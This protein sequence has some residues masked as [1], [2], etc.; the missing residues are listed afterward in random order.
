M[1]TQKVILGCDVSQ[2]WLDY[3]RHGDAQTVQI[4]NDQRAIDRWLRSLNPATAALAIEATNTYHELLVERARHF[5]LEVYLVSGYQ[6]RHYALSLNVRMRND[7]VDAQLLARFLDREIEALRPYEPRSAEHQRLMR[8]LKRRALLVRQRIQLRQSFAGL[9]ELRTSVRSVRRRLQ[10]LIALI[11]R[12]LQHLAR[13]LGWGPDL[14]RLRSLPGVGPLNALALC[15][16]YRSG[17]FS[18]RDPFIAFLGLDVRTKDSGKHRGRRKLTKKGDPEYRRLLYN[19]AMAATRDGRLLQDKY[20]ALQ[21]RGLSKTAALVAVSRHI[22]RLAF[23]LL[24][25]QTSF[26]PKLV[27]RPCL[28]T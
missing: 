27:R 14:A 18:H 28:T 7:R 20:Q 23:A 12:R 21:A 24:K 1:Q 10:Q 26:D 5:G 25:N 15:A 4:A 22:A 8:L 17:Q 19:A 3:C 9:G 6:L 2:E 13:K 11:D 16:A